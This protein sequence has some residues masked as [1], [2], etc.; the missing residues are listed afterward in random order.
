MSKIQVPKVEHGE[1]QKVPPPMKYIL[2]TD[3]ER[4]N[5]LSSISEFYFTEGH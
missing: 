1:R 5:D 2:F 3:I 4:Q